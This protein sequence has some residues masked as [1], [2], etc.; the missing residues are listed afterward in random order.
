[1]TKKIIT[2]TTD[3][4]LRDPYVAEMK[5]VILG[6]CSEPAIVDVTHEIEKFN[7][8]MGA[9]VLASA[10]PYF[11][12][13][14]IHV[15][16][17]DPG[18]GTKRRFLLIQTR[19]GFFVGPDNGVLV[20]AAEKQGIISVHE[21]TNPKLMLPNVSNTFHGRDVF[22][23]AAAHL[24]NGVSPA[25]FGPEI[26]EVAKPEFSKVTFSKG[27]L[28]GEVLYV[29]GFGNIITN[30]GKEELARIHTQ[31]SINVDMPSGK[32][33]LKLGKTYAETKPKEALILVGSHGYVEIAVNQGNAA[34]KFQTRPGDKIKLSPT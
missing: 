2:L 21:I 10:A 25:D 8:R 3:F 15:V 27:T 32:V 33:R 23:P 6:I 14:T 11:P 20:L 30:V 18:V 24:A 16:V 29:D 4:G 28:M 7:I 22:A 1:L 19:Q 17:V 34:E 9:Y 31:D 13:E 12:K 5:A 26:K